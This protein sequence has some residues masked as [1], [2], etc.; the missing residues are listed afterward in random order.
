MR[1]TPGEQVD[2]VQ[3]TVRGRYPQ[4]FAGSIQHQVVNDIAEQPV[5][6]VATAAVDNKMASIVAIKTV[7]GA[8]PDI[9][10]RILQDFIDIV[11]AQPVL[12]G[13]FMTYR[14]LAYGL[15]VDRREDDD[16]DKQ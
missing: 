9:P 2:P 12:G 16:Q 14:D 4:E 10:V 13:K 7:P 8:E 15:P 5:N 6:T 1:D 11:T 3:A